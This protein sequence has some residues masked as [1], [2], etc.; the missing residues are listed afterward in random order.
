MTSCAE[1]VQGQ[2]PVARRRT[3]DRPDVQKPE[4]LPRLSCTMDNTYCIVTPLLFK[5]I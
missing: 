3:F 5:P 1:R 2:S 4:L